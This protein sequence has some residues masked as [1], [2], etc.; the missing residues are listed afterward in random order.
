MFVALAV[1]FS[2]FIACDKKSK[3]IVSVLKRMETN[4]KSLNTFR[5]DMR[6]EKFNAQLGETDVY[7]GKIV[8]LKQGKSTSHVRLDWKKPA[9]E[10]L[11]I[12]K[13]EYMLYRPRLKQ[14]II[15]KIDKLET[16]VA[17]KDW[18]DFLNKS[19]SELKADLDFKYLDEQKLSNGILTQ[20]LELTSKTAK[21]Y[22]KIEF[23]TDKSG[24]L[25]QLKIIEGNNDSI[26]VLFSNIEKNPIINTEIFKI[27]LPKNTV[28]VRS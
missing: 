2:F 11:L 17:L 4:Y 14:A 24:M 20:H 8:F 7:E 25:I 3:K 9:E 23:W 5:A 1:S 19:R 18:L 16:S 26:T 12:V 10:S 27:N 6:M 15:G 28:I 22:K 13:Q 21:K